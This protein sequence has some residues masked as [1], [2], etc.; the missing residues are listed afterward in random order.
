M[1][2]T[3]VCSFFAAS[4]IS[5]FAGC[6]SLNKKS[7]STSTTSSTTTNPFVSSSKKVQQDLTQ[8]ETDLGQME[9]QIKIPK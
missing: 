7:P 6:S 1:L 3:I 8:T 5:G 2:R 4:L 9:S